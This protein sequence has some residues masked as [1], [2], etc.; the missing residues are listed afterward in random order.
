[1][2]IES[3]LGAFLTSPVMIILGTCD[4]HGSP[5]IG[6]GVGARIDGGGATVDV[7][8]SSWQWPGTVANV[9]NSGRAAITFARPSD[10]VTYQVKGRAQI[11]EYD[12]AASAIC[13]QYIPS[14]THVLCSLGL[15]RRLI[16]DWL[17][18]RDAV[19]IRLCIEAVFVQTPGAKAGSP[20]AAHGT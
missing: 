1:M 19:L 3:E 16:A 17:T 2:Q 8:V 11:V 6:R 20:I 10:Y 4:A 15:E 7:V 12:A 5:D 14:I 13:S 9:R 18:D